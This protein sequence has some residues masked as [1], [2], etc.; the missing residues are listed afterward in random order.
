MSKCLNCGK[1]SGKYTL[2]FAC[3]KLKAEG[4][5]AK[6]EKCGKYY[7]PSQKC[8]CEQKE[9][10]KAKKE[11]T[12]K[13]LDK[14]IEKPLSEKEA[15]GDGKCIVCGKDAPKGYLCYD[16]FKRKEEIKKDLD[17][18]SEADETKDYYNNLKYS[19]YK[20]KRMDYA[21]NACIK[22]YA[23]SEI[24]ERN[25]KYRGFID[26]GAVAIVDLLTKKKEYLSGKSKEVP[27][28]DVPEASLDVTEDLKALRDKDVKDYRKIYPMNL[29]CTDGHYVRSKAEREIDN[30]FYIKNIR[31]AYEPKY[32]AQDDK[33]YYP[34]FYLP[35]YLL[36]IEY[37]GKDDEEYLGKADKKIQIYAQDKEVAFEYLFPKDDNTLEDRLEE[38]LHKRKKQLDKK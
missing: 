6:C 35:D 9:E 29:H 37:F 16:C 8:E 19:I 21:Q 33:E 4:K 15:R 20:I 36:Y 32:R 11:E 13:P 17:Y 31:H 26:K 30:Y 25:F 2:C 28:E 24:L 7:D 27:D 1:E 3:N 10:K 38:I 23:I 12:K 14:T 18:L 22:L 5:I 34:D